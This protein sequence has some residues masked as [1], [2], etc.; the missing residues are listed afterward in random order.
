MF[1]L[2]CNYTTIIIMTLYQYFSQISYFIVSLR[3]TCLSNV[4]FSIKLQIIPVN[5]RRAMQTFEI[6][7]RNV[8]AK[9]V[10]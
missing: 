2:S 3:K 10:F 8:K 5:H 4:K 6:L 1:K 7:Q 9:Y